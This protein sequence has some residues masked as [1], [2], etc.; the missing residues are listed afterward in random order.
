[1]PQALYMVMELGD[2]TS[3]PSKI[4]SKVHRYVD[5][6]YVEPSEAIATASE[7]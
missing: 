2:T 3:R 6:M 5:T 4:W 1:M 7:L